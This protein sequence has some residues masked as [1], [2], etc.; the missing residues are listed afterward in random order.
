[1]KNIT[2]VALGA[3]VLL[4]SCLPVLATP[5]TIIYIPS[6]DVQAPKTMHLGLDTYFTFDGK[7]VGNTVDTGLTWGFKKFEVGVDHVGGTDDPF[8]GNIKFQA[9]TESSKMP[10]ISL[11]AYNLGGK[12]NGLAGNLW[13]VLG[14]KTFQFGRLHLGYQHGEKSRVGVDENMLLAAWDK[15]LNK[16]WWGAADYASGDSAFG[17]LSFGAGYTFSENTSVVFGYD[18]YNNGAFEDTITV[19]VDINF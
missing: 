16:K 13:Y 10:A 1:M 12:K 8:M 6:T 3:L 18:I 4:G 5:S 2:A 15:Q 17:A 19:Q 9:L 11:G 14:S 7:G